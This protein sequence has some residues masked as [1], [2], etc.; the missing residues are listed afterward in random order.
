VATA[1]KDCSATFTELSSISGREKVIL[2]EP[3]AADRNSYRKAPP[4]TSKLNWRMETER[5]GA[6]P[7]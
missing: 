2:R 3:L 6:R 5:H 1:Q 4:G 7:E